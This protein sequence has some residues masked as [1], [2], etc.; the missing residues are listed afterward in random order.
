MNAEGSPIQLCQ[1][2]H[3]CSSMGSRGG[4]DVTEVTIKC[5][6]TECVVIGALL[7]L[8]R[9]SGPV[10]PNDSDLDNFAMMGDDDGSNHGPSAEL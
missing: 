10:Y 5:C 1:Q 6:C 7:T 4:T 2:G 3:S 9:Q 8:S